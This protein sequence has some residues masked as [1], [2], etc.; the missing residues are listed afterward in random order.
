MME[1][2]EW[3]SKSAKSPKFARWRRICS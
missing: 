2:P 1:P 3:A